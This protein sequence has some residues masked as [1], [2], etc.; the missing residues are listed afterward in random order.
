MRNRQRWMAVALVG[1]SIG[2]VGCPKKAAVKPSEKATKRQPIE[3]KEE[4]TIRGKEYRAIPQVAMVY[5]D[6][7]KAELRSDAKPA[8]KKNAEYLET[9]A[10]LEVLV[11]GHCDERGTV[12]YNLGLGQRR[13]QAVRQYYASLGVSADRVATISYGKEKPVCADSTEDCWQRN[14][15]AESKVRSTSTTKS[16]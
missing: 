14:R 5:F 15:R 3:T 2:L 10:D 9:H 11:D 12:A 6:F 1:M 4:P 13:A 8:L 16:R 7:D